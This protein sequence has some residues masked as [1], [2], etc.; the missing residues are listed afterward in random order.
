MVTVGEPDEFKAVR[1]AAE[2]PA[3]WA[4]ESAGAEQGAN[5]TV[6]PAQGAGT[7]LTAASVG[8]V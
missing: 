2:V 8:D 6:D 7:T 3:A 5:A 1:G 4:V